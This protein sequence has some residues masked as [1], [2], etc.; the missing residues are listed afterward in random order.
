MFQAARTAS[1]KSLPSRPWQ[2]WE[3]ANMSEWLKWSE[4]GQGLGWGWGT[5]HLSPDRLKLGLG[6]ALQ[7]GDKEA[8]AEDPH[9]VSIVLATVFRTDQG[10][11]GQKQGNQTA[12]YGKNPGDREQH[13][14]TSWRWHEQNFL[15]DMTWRVWETQESRVSPR[16]W[17][18][19]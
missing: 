17:P 13:P 12:G 9:F 14:N 11:E 8:W 15:M 3:T 6:L 1:A 18:E 5:D 7:D 19:Q 10:R 16:F 2:V 4:Q